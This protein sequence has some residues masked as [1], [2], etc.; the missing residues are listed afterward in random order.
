[1]AETA[2]SETNSRMARPLALIT[3]A[4]SGI[5]AAFAGAYAKRGFDLALVARRADRLE[6]LAERLHAAHGVA[7]FAV[8]ADL[9]AFDAP[10][11]V[12]GAVAERGRVVDVLV[13]NAGFGIPQ[14][15]VDASWA[16]QR[17]FLT[18]MALS[19]CGL[20]HGVIPG[21]IERGRGAILN[22]ASV[23]GFSPGVAGNSLY[24][25]VKSL[26][27]KFSQSLDAEYR[28]RGLKITAVCP[29]FTRTEFA[30][31]AGIESAAARE[32]RLFWQSAEAVVEAAI[33]GNERGR[34]VVVPGWHNRLSVFLLRSLPEPLVRAVVG[35]AAAKYI[36]ERDDH[37]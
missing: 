14:R 26:M 1:M 7:A 37:G 9:A 31:K 4:S 19:P 34:V 36:P 8:P 20:A 30:A 15:F 33:A 23:A 28:G 24:P 6:A 2:S 11:V 17:D 21:M 18:T 16:R 5:G 13:N 25:G 27:I 32:S 35:Q 12:L 3:G 22:I 10:A 29:G